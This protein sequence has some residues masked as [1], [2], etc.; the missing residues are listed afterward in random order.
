M[1]VLVNILGKY[2]FTRVNT[3]LKNPVV[4][5]CVPGAGKSSCIRE[6]L[7]VD[8]RFV[9][10]TAGLEDKP[11]IRGKWIR[12]FTG[13]V[14]E[15]KFN[16]LDEYTLVEKLP[17]NLFAVFGDPLQSNLSTP[18][19]ADFICSHS[20]RFGTATAQLLRDLNFN[21]TAEGLDCVQIADIFSVDPRDQILF[22]EK[23]VGEL[24]CRHNLDAK[25]I[26]EVVGQTFDSVTFVTGERGPTS[27]VEAFQCLTRH[28]KSLLI[29]CP[30]ASYTAT[31]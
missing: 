2:G 29:L 25:H 11:N 30:D 26:S 16:L 1:D 7:E 15:G 10:F 23:E 8:S 5:N 27:A 6:L 3:S 17:T 13:T 22:F 28:R 14:E 18:L 20:R 12:K 4:I 21:V 19:C 31:R 24:L 9:A